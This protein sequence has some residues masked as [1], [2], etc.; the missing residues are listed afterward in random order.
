MTPDELPLTPAKRD[1][2]QAML[3]SAG[4]L[5]GLQ[6]CLDRA[7]RTVTRHIT[8]YTFTASEL[9]DWQGALALWE[10]YQLAGVSVPPGIKERGEAAQKAIEA[11]RDGKFPGALNPAAPARSPGVAITS[12]CDV[13]G[14]LR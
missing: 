8:G 7:E 3:A 9:A 1:Q 10:A 11:V 14:S 13:D 5:D 6:A 12:D 4:V 2:L